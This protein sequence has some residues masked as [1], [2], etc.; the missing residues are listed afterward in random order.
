MTDDA[1]AR[2][3]HAAAAEITR[4]YST[5]YTMM[6]IELGSVG[7]ERLAPHY[8]GDIVA[9]A[10]RLAIERLNSERLEAAIAAEEQAAAEPA[11]RRQLTID[12]ALA[13]QAG[14]G[15]PW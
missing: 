7:A 15:T 2:Q 8:L 6:E 1:F 4:L 10:E 12:E 14:G 9:A 13:E 3:F 5:A 11:A